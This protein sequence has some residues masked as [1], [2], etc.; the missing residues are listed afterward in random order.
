MIDPKDLL[1]IV[2]A[3]C[4]IWCTAFFCWLLYQV[5]IVVRGLNVLLREVKLQFERIERLI[6]GMKTKFETSTTHLGEMAEHLKAAVKSGI[7]NIK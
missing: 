1:F 7:K 3:L 4:A 6:A 5:I 2:L